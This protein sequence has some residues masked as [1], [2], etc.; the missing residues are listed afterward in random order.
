MKH[1]ELQHLR[2]VKHIVDEGSMSNATQKM[3]LTQSTLSHMLREM[4]NNIGMQ[5][6]SRRS[7]KLHLT[8]AGAAILRHGEKILSEFAELE[9]TLA[10]IKADKKERIRISTSCY[11]SYHWLPAVVKLFRKQHPAAT[12]NI[13]TEAT[14]NPLAFLENAKLDVA[15][16]DTKPVLP[17]AYRTDLLFED[18][19]LLLVSPDSHYT[20]LNRLTAGAFNGAD[21]FIYDMDEQNSTAINGFIRPN[22]IRL[23]SIVKMQL[24]EGL[25]EM[26]AADL[27]FTIM[28]AWMAQPYLDQGKVIAIPLPGKA[29][30]RKWYAISYKKAGKVQGQFIELL[31]KELRKDQI[32]LSK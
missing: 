5:V 29:L 7:K 6:F 17:A 3:F 20:G 16:T 15:I 13:I 30:K 19:F 9:K 27:G 31:R 23:N 25:I 11:T 4:E 8:D 32:T 2:L 21:L 28:P 24:T 14:Q 22:N 12:V 26:V 1:V 18:E 10:G